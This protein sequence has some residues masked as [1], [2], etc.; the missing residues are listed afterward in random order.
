MNR[1][2]FVEDK[3]SEVLRSIGLNKA[4]IEVYIDLLK[5]SS[6]SALNIS[7]RTH[8][9]RS[10]TY[11]SLRRLIEKGLIKESVEDNKRFFIAKDPDKIKEYM[12]QKDQEVDKIIPSLKEIT[13]KDYNER[14]TALSYGPL[15]LRSALKEAIK[16]NKPMYIWAMSSHAE[17]LG[18]GFMDEF[19]K[20]RIQKKVHLKMIIHKPNP[21]LH[22][23]NSKPYTEVKHIESE[24]DYS[25]MKIVCGDSIYLLV[26]EKPLTAIEIRSKELA[27][28]FVSSFNTIWAS[29]VKE[30]SAPYKVNRAYDKKVV[31]QSAD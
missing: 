5:Y 14:K 25:T 22:L 30:T 28:S 16:L 31:L 3:I 20:E 6:S 15:S 7:K 10:N 13:Q 17:V 2:D 24:R 21:R 18:E 11:D 23:L 12:K 29:P 9:Y 1:K 8:L 4:E 27:D 19:H 26:L